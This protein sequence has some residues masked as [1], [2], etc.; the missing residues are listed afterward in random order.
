MYKNYGSMNSFYTIICYS[1]IFILSPFST[2]YITL[3]LGSR[4]DMVSKLGLVSMIF[5]LSLSLQ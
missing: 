4:V 5:A 1:I 2:N 3:F